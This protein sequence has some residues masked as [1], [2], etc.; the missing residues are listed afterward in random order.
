MGIKMVINLGLV[1]LLSSVETTLSPVLIQLQIEEMVE[2][3]VNGV[4]VDMR[5]ADEWLI[6]AQELVPMAIG[7]GKRSEGVSW[8]MEDDNFEIGKDPI[9]FV[10]FVESSLFLQEYSLQRAVAGGFEDH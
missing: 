9:S 10:G 4:S 5:S 8:Q 2:D 3:S 6:H 7:Q 1:F